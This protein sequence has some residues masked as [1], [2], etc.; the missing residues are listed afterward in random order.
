MLTSSSPGSSASSVGGGKM[1][2]MNN[3]NED[4]DGRVGVDSTRSSLLSVAGLGLGGSLGL[5]LGALVLTTTQHQHYATSTTT[6]ISS[7]TLALINS[8]RYLLRGGWK[9]PAH[10]LAITVPVSLVSSLL[11]FEQIRWWLTKSHRKRAIRRHWELVVDS[12]RSGQQKHSTTGTAAKVDK[13]AKKRRVVENFPIED[14]D[15]D[16]QAMLHSPSCPLS[17]SSSAHQVIDSEV[18]GMQ[19]SKSLVMAS[20]RVSE[21]CNDVLM[22][23]VPSASPVPSDDS[24]EY[25]ETLVSFNTDAGGRVDLNMSTT[26]TTVTP[27]TSTTE[28]MPSSS[29]ANTLSRGVNPNTKELEKRMSSATLTSS[30]VRSICTCTFGDSAIDLI[31]ISNLKMRQ[32]SVV[33]TDNDGECNDEEISE[34][35]EAVGV[36]VATSD[37]SSNSKEASIWMWKWNSN[38]HSNVHHDTDKDNITTTIAKTTTTTTTMSTISATS[39]A[40]ASSI[41]GPLLSLLPLTNPSRSAGSCCSHEDESPEPLWRQRLF[42]SLT[43]V[44]RFVNPWIE[45]QDRNT[46]DFF[47]YLTWQATRRCRNGVPKD[48][49]EVDRRLPVV[50]PEVGRKV[51]EGFHRVVEASGGGDNELLE[52]ENELLKSL[53]EVGKPVMSVAWFGQST[54]FVQMDGYN[55]LT[56]P[57]FSSRTVGE[58]VGPKRV[59]RV[60]CTLSDL[61]KVD[62]VLVSH[63]HYDHLDRAI[64]AELKNSV[65]WYIPLGLKT[66][67]ASLGVTNVVELDWWQEHLHEGKLL[68]AGLPI[69]HWSGR[70]FFDVNQSLWAS[71]LVK[72]PTCSFFHVGDTGYCS[73]FKEIGARYG[74]VTFAAIPIGSYEPRYFMRHQ[75]IDP[76]EAVQIHKDVGAAHS[77]GVHWGTFMMSDEYYLDPPVVFDHARVQEGLEVGSTVTSKLGEVVVVVVV[78]DRSGD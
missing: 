54:C 6:T 68:I 55:I 10:H 18:S 69:Q 37:A 30:E 63:N 48:P 66:W 57:I 43:V 1:T 21:E 7:S 34:E 58:W 23:L 64:V 15:D 53:V 20:S 16:E 71:F 24:D 35:E 46:G 62:I 77:V 11:F 4:G 41:I 33:R 76:Y 27:T 72:G 36:V 25:A 13:R 32:R 70:H 49:E 40:I 8:G 52:G 73:A 26:V 28:R 75:H 65:T 45:W 38:S 2:T 14:V 47:A 67:F 22:P 31:S 42:H 74:P 3:G 5:G 29:F 17:R 50:G 60:P 51:W 59:Q 44:G 9:L 12:T 78:K 61:P 56:D 19:Q 39:T